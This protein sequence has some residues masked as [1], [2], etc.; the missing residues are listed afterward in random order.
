MGMF[1]PNEDDLNALGEFS[2]GKEG[3]DWKEMLEYMKNVSSV[4]VCVFCFLGL[5][6]TFAERK[7]DTS[8]ILRREWQ[9]NRRRRRPQRQDARHDRFVLTY[10]S[11]YVTRFTHAHVVRLQGYVKKSLPNWFATSHAAIIQAA[12]SE[13]IKRN[14]EPVSKPV[15]DLM[16]ALTCSR[17][18]LRLSQGAGNNL[19][20]YTTW[21]NVDTAD[22]HRRS[23]PA[24]D[25]LP[26]ASDNLKVLCGATAS[27]VRPARLGHRPTLITRSS[28]A[29][30]FGK[31]RINWPSGFA[32]GRVLAQ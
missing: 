7:D 1:R 12:E 23:Y 32:R 19:G 4:V 26:H 18:S 14:V 8:D 21:V 20:V 10:Y 9:E 5:M 6:S 11:P 24:L 22:G 27:K 15:R 31:E 28:S 17:T 30:L 2:G 16:C 25:C 29:D 3:W 13:G